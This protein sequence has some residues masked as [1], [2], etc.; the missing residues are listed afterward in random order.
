MTRQVALLAAVGAL[1]YGGAIALAATSDHTSTG[2]VVIAIAAG[3]SFTV[4]G[5]V[6]FVRRPDNRTGL[7]M[8]AV[9][10]L[11]ALGSLQL[12]RSSA[13]FTIGL[14]GE[15]LAFA[16]LAHLLLAYP[17]GRL[18]LRRH[19]RL[20]AAV[21]ATVFVGPILVGLFDPTPTGCAKCPRSAILVIDDHGL[22]VAAS[23]LFT[24]A[25]VALALWA[26][27]ELVIRF[28]RASRPLRRTVAPV[29]L[30]FFVALVLIIAANVVTPVSDPASTGLGTTAIVC[31]ALVPIAFLVGILRSRL[32]RASVAGLV[33][34]LERGT[35]LRDAL[36]E[37]VGDPSVEIAYW[38]ADRERWVDAEGRPVSAP[39]AT[40]RRAVTTVESHGER[41]AA[42]V[43]DA[44][45]GDQPELVDAVA[46]AAAMALQTERLQ[47]QLRAQYEFLLAV[48]D[49]APS[50]LVIVDVDGRIRHQN[51]AVLEATGYEDEEQVRGRF[52]WEVFIG[53]DERPAMRQRF[54]DAAPDFPPAEY[55]NVFTNLRG[56]ERVI[57]WRSAPVRDDSG[58]VVSIIAGGID[59]TERKRQ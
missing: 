47:A 1:V 36:S 24:V 8:L 48:V 34:A 58:A 33:L 27:A 26:L 52:F 57:A 42:L 3:L 11:W 15:E 17:T 21:G 22:A 31:I 5:V 25:A 30:T 43:H 39:S 18:D 59:I 9:G 37:A 20:V 6:A 54:F 16:P 50:L 29:Y 13:L 14:V 46:A 44:S 7:L 28:R 32:A 56:E 41:V 55:E 53:D 19:R 2:V 23:V 51:A 40:R 35:P 10:F 12:T 4:T 45:L 49:T 38:L